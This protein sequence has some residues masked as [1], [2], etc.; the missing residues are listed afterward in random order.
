MAHFEK[1]TLTESRQV[2][3]HDKRKHTDHTEHI[4][5]ARSHLNYDLGPGG[6]SWEFIQKKIDMSKSAGGR[7]NSRSV[8]VVSCV[9]TLPK[10][11]VGDERLF[12]ETAKKHLDKIFGADN[13]I[14]A[15][16]HKDEQGQP[17]IHYK[18][19]PVIDNQFNAK[20]IVNRKFLQRFHK[21]LEDT[22][23]QTFG[24]KVGILN[25][26]TTRGNITIPQLKEQTEELHRI[27]RDIKK[28]R[29]KLDKIN[30][31]GQ[32]RVAEVNKLNKELRTLTDRLQLVTEQ[33][34]Q[35]AKDL[36]EV[37]HKT[38]NEVLGEDWD[39]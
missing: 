5:P 39:R 11:F 19:T 16:V 24:H 18:A 23:E 12:F 22:M 6:D 20:K 9:V 29:Q 10:D 34:E 21:D 15:V 28:A 36:E 13:C 35:K 17:H 37:G 2:C 30:Q 31:I 4:D 27:K 25:G 8:I 1:Y 3:Y 38:A 32:E 33:L 14:S 26:A 7:V